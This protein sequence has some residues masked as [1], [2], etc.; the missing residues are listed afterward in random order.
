MSPYLKLQLT[1]NALSRPAGARC[2][3]RTVP[4]P[5]TRAP[6]LETNS[7]IYFL[8]GAAGTALLMF[9]LEQ[10]VETQNVET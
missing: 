5:H 1:N 4:R 8:R 3:L 7:N 9:L 2:E 6:E 10:D